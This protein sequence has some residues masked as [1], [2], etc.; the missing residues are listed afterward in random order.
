V[1]VGEVV[2][3][4]WARFKQNWALLVFSYVIVAVILQI[5]SRIT[6]SALGMSTDFQ[7]RTYWVALGGSTV[8]NQIVNAY[9]QPGLLRICSAWPA[10]SRRAS[11]AL[12]GVR[13]LLAD[14]GLTLLSGFASGL[15][16]SS[17]SSRRHHL[18]R[19]LPGAVLPGRRQDGPF[20]AM[21][22]SWNATKGQKADVFL[23]VLA[24]VGWGCSV[25]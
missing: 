25:S 12:L 7:S 15:G 17:S 10:V 13:S 23:L 16:S 21:K 19:S 14:A 20:E 2:S 9:F 3:L 18:P 8:A 22:A 4:G 24:G 1:G 6:Q 11:G 5:V